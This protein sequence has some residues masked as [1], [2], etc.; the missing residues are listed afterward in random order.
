MTLKK[1]TRKSLVNEK[2]RKLNIIFCAM[3]LCISLGAFV[4]LSAYA[5]GDD[6]FTTSA[7]E[8]YVDI[9]SGCRY[10][11]EGKAYHYALEGVADDAIISS[12]LNGTYTSGSVWV[13]SVGGISYMVYKD[14][15]EYTPEEEGSFSEPG[16]YAI[17]LYDKY[18]K[19]VVPLKFRILGKIGNDRR[20]D[21]PGTCEIE[22]VKLNGEDAP[23]DKASV[24]LS[25]EG[26]YEIHYRVI[27]IDRTETITVLIDNTAPTLK[28][29]GVND[30]N[31]ANGPVQI[32]GIEENSKIS[33]LRNGKPYN[34][35]KKIVD[36]GNYR[37]TVRDEAG[38]Q[39]MY[40]FV[41]LSYFNISSWVFLGLCLV[42]VIGLIAYIILLRKNLRVR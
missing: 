29:K 2:L 8:H 13:K 15:N 28:F 17:A 18:G 27:A 30:K 42:V 35:K 12:A 40:E 4:P 25:G 14:G 38:N 19:K 10:D 37:V 1:E 24:S 32:S 21:F 16:D 20:Y 39:T 26:T 34:F 6:G 23:F 3:F 9:Y 5:A 22:Y 7:D 36:S 11:L 31:Q 33:I 41:I